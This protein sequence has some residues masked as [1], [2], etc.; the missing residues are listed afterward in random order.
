MYP[1]LEA[2]VQEWQSK[3][4]CLGLTNEVVFQHPQ[5][6]GEFMTGFIRL[7]IE[8][9]PHAKLIEL[10]RSAM[11]TITETPSV[12]FAAELQGILRDS[13]GFTAWKTGRHVGATLEANPEVKAALS[14]TEVAALVA[15]EECKHG[16]ANSDDKPLELL[17]AALAPELRE[18]A[19]GRPVKV[20]LQC[21]LRFAGRRSLLNNLADAI[22]GQ[23]RNR[24]IQTA[25][26]WLKEGG[27][28]V[29][30]HWEFPES[31]IGKENGNGVRDWL[32]R[33]R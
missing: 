14:T 29:V 17:E 23:L 7:L 13:C 5:E 30:R 2:L 28:Q 1:K 4:G 11:R 18:S 8:E 12:D 10:L 9:T 32:F 33:R 24:L 19:K 25:L 15:H 20:A 27:V 6:A 3:T 26:R 22:K 16:W 21:A 31:P